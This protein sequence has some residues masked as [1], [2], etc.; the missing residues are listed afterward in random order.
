MCDGG[1][2]NT[3]H[4]RPASFKPVRAV[5]LSLAGWLADYLLTNNTTTNTTSHRP[6]H[7]PHHPDTSLR[8]PPSVILARQGAKSTNKPTDTPSSSGP[9]PQQLA[10]QLQHIPSPPISQPTRPNPFARAGTRQ[11]TTVKMPALTSAAGLV[12]FLSEPDPTL[13]AFA[14]E[15]LNEEIDSV[16]TEV[17]GSIGQMYV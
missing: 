4:H 5:R 16:W 17:T 14:L 15:R 10:C 3:H 7:L 12:G 6:S 1:G 2:Q 13:Q 8:L 9:P 11:H